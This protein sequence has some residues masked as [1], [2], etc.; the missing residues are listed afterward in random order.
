VYRPLVQYYRATGFAR[1]VPENASEQGL[2][3]FLQQHGL[4]YGYATYWNSHVVTVIS[5]GKVKVRPIVLSPVQGMMHLSSSQWYRPEAHVGPTFLVLTPQEVKLVEQSNLLAMTGPP[6][7]TLHHRDYSIY[8]FNDNF[9][10]RI[11]AWDFTLKAPTHVAYDST[12]PHTVGRYVA[13]SGDQAG[14]GW[15]QSERGEVGALA[16][17]PYVRLQGGNY[18]ASFDVAGCSADAQ[19][20]GTADISALV[21]DAPTVVAARDLRLDESW[22][23]ITVPFTLPQA[24]TG[25]EWRVMSNGSSCLKA[26]GVTVRR[27]D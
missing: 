3:R 26:R 24:R 17:G 18:V 19:A 14:P 16:Y 2:S 25:V 6:R 8:V 7:E 20:G 4:T 11:P 22:T 1:V 5:G 21:N 13:A 9:G 23:A 12:T 27:I 10:G 15:L